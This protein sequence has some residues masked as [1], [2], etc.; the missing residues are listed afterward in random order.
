M[1]DVEGF[2]LQNRETKQLV[3]LD[4]S[5]GG[6]PWYPN[7]FHNIKIWPSRAEAAHYYETMNY[8]F[9]NGL[10]PEAE[11]WDIVAVKVG[12]EILLAPE[13]T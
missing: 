1:Y 2:A 8:K 5:S 13:E 3:G 7:S 11:P 9:T 4:A 6:Y 12:I 10:G